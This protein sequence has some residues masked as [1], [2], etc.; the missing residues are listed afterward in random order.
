MAATG[1]LDAP[2]GNV[3]YVNPPTRTVAEFARHKDLTPEQRTKR[4][5]GEQFKLGARVALITPKMAWDSILNGKPYQ[6]KAGILCGTNPV[7]TRANA[8]RPTRP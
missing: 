3:L 6:L 1:N 7:I 5:G 2:G 4:L 8:Q